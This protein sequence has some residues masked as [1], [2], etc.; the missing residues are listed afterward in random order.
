MFPTSSYMFEHLVSS[1]WHCFERLWDLLSLGPS[2]QTSGCG[3]GARWL[4]L[5]S[6]C[7][8]SLLPSCHWVQLVHSHPATP[9][10]SHSCHHAFSATVHH[11]PLAN[12]DLSNVTESSCHHPSPSV[13][14]GLPSSF[15]PNTTRLIPAPGP[16]ALTTLCSSS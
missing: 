10:T 4:Y 7:L 13:S 9:T 15:I 16:E 6:S 11:I 14:C 5:G 8:R 12:H 1:C 2:E 3:G